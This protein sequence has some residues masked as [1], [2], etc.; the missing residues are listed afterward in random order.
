MAMLFVV[1]LLPL[2]GF[3]KE[4]ALGLVAS[5]GSVY[6]HRRIGLRKSW[7]GPL[8]QVVF[9]VPA[10]TLALWV[11]NRSLG[12]HGCGV[13]A[14]GGALDFMRVNG[15]IRWRMSRPRRPP[16]QQGGCAGQP[17]VGGEIAVGSRPGR[18]DAAQFRP[19]RGR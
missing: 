13:P 8:E 2:F 18:A 17:N 4:L 11:D 14:W 19:S 9:L 16:S 7:L 10:M 15:L 5:W 6:W 12:R 3:W 1:I